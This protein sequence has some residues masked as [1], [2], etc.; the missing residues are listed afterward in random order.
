MCVCNLIFFLKSKVVSVGKESSIVSILH[1]EKYSDVS[2]R[3]FKKKWLKRFV[4][5][6]GAYL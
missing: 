2:S 6:A 1:T 5:D 4:S 3:D